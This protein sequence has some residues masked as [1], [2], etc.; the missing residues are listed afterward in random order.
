MMHIGQIKQ[1]LGISGMATS[2]STWR[3]NNAAENTQIDL[4]I[5]RSDRTI[6]VCEI[7][8]SS[9]PY[10]ISKDYENKLRMRNAIFRAETKTTKALAVTFVTVFGVVPNI[11]SGIVHSEVT[12]E[13]LCK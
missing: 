10:T 8:F 4:L 13:D 5:D 6:N 12:A 3:S 11:H 7:K 9:E 2:V 1:K